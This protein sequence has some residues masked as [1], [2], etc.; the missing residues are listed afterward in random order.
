M[1]MGIDPFWFCFSGRR[2]KS[3]SSTSPNTCKYWQRTWNCDMDI[4]TNSRT[5]AKHVWKEN[6]TKNIWPNTRRGTLAS[7]MEQW[8]LQFV[9][10]AK[11]CGGHYNQK[12]RMGRSHKKNGRIKDSKKGFKRKSLYHNISGKTK[13]QMGGC[14]PEGCI[15]TDGDKRME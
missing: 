12:I 6:I 14:V 4:N 13:K 15:T 1:V 2:I 11:H 5:L 7:Q 8:T 9:Q 3:N 10:W